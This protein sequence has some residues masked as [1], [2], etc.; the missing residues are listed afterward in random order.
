[1][2]QIKG[3]RLLSFCWFAAS[4]NI[5]IALKDFDAWE[6]KSRGGQAGKEAK[7]TCLRQL[8]HGLVCGVE[9]SLVA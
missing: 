3:C 7:W 5:S 6:R 8:A 2:V 4:G 9:V 1:M